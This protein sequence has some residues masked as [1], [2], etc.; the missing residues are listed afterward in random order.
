V[1]DAL[2]SWKV[3]KHDLDPAA[4]DA[5]EFADLAY[6]QW[7]YYGRGLA[8][9][10]TLRELKSI[11][12]NNPKAEVAVLLLAKV[13]VG[14]LRLGI[15]GICLFRRTWYN[16]IYI[17]FLVKHPLSRFGGT[18]TALL[19]FLTLVAT[20]LKCDAIWGETTQ[21]S[22]DF[23]ER[24]IGTKMTDMLYLDRETYEALARQAATSK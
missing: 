15:G 5:A 14:R 19:R 13:P 22:V 17:D 24:A 9:A 8:V 2:K 18:G 16:N 20:S 23:Y 6:R 21:N 7:A 3:A 12:R 4:R 11:I 10:R 1:R